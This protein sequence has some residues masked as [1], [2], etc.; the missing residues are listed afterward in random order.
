MGDAVS[1]IAEAVG[2]KQPKEPKDVKEARKEAER[3]KAAEQKRLQA[4][5][6]KERHRRRARLGGRYG[7]RSLVYQPPEDATGETLGGG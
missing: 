1:G 5:Q 2:L 4:Q 6:R 3:L 7:R